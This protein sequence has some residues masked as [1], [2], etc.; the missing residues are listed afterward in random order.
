ME[1]ETSRPAEV[2]TAIGRLRLRV[3]VGYADAQRVTFTSD[4]WAAKLRAGLDRPTADR[5]LSSVAKQTAAAGPDGPRTIP[6]KGLYELARRGD[7]AAAQFGVTA[8]GTGTNT[9]D[10][11]RQ[12]ANLLRSVR[13][14]RH[15]RMAAAVTAAPNGL[16]AMWDAHFSRPV[17]QGFGQASYGTKWLHA[18][19]WDAVPDQDPRPVVFDQF[20]HR[21]LDVC[22]GIDLPYPGRPT[23]AV[24]D[25][26]IEWCRIAT[27]AACHGL[28]AADVERAVFDHRRSCAAHRGAGP[29]PQQT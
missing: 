8:W 14:G 2:E 9:L 7:T 22:A 6:R 19:G 10:R 12:A 1:S 21:V 5:L 11:G 13:T 28:T 23:D 29:C 26:W 4:W 20:V 27:D 18:A 16:A 24:R 15:E 17:A 25:G 3:A